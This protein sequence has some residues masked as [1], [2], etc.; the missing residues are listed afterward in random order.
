MSF[1]GAIIFG[2][3][4]AYIY[5]LIREEVKEDVKDELREE[6]RDELEGEKDSD[7]FDSYNLYLD[8]KY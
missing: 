3:A 8:D 7:A 6:L 1:I 4:I 2:I 5:Y